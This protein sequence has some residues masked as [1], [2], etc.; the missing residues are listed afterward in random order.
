MHYK[1]KAKPWL[2]SGENPWVFVSV[3][4]ELS[5]EI[6]EVTSSVKRGFGSVRVAV[7]VNSIEWRTSI[8][9]DS[10]TQTY[11][12]PLKKD[13]RKSA[14]IQTDHTYEFEISIEGSV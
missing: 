13:V 10:K 8:F 4:K 12:L 3:P 6:K 5:A 14:H 1:F 2:Y 7:K 9:P 11:L